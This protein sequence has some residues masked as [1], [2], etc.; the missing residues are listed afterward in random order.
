[1]GIVE[2]LDD[3]NII[4]PTVNPK[5]SYSLG[6]ISNGLLFLSG[7]GPLLGK[8]GP[9][10]G[11][12]G[13]DLTVAE[14]YEAARVTAINCIATA[15]SHL[16]DLRRL[17]SVASVTLFIRSSDDFVRHSD[18]A[19]G[20]TDMFQSLLTGTPLASRCAVGVASLPFGLCMEANV[21]FNVLD[22]V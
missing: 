13:R 10:T 15:Q 20:C 17:L 16:G 18:V 12:V 7:Q 2:R 21:V 8:Q 22:T 14:G 1:M 5:G 3:L 19:D 11:I 6:S 4:L 9:V